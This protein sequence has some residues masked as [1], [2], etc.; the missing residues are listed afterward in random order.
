MT[1]LNGIFKAGAFATFALA[2]THGFAENK[3]APLSSPADLKLGHDHTMVLLEWNHAGLSTTYAFMR[4]YDGNVHL[5][6]KS[7][8]NSKV[9]V[10]IKADSLDSFNPAR[11]KV[12]KSQRFLNVAEYP[13]ITFKS[14]EVKRTGDG[15]ATMAGDMT[16]LGKS[17]PV[18][19]DVTFNKAGENMGEFI[20][21]FDAK[22]VLD[23]KDLGIVDLYPKV[24]PKVT[25]HISTELVHAK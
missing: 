9:D 24:A 21:G 6:P 2:A 15:T 17:H 23:R 4:E 7:P 8:E 19:F 16:I 3:V 11:D 5:D 14:T 10:T 18:V 22:T 20:A 1:K 25:V 12:L 13:D